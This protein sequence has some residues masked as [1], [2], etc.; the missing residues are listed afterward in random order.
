MSDPSVRDSIRELLAHIEACG[1]NGSSLNVVSESYAANCLLPLSPSQSHLLADLVTV[2]VPRST[3]W[4]TRER[5][6]SWALCGR[7][8]EDSGP[9][10]TVF[11]LATS[12]RDVLP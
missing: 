6:E 2:L 12:D 4:S 5:T 3:W 1:H 10:V 8:G 7:V 11:I 9:Q